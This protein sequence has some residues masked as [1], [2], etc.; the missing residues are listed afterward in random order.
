MTRVGAS[1]STDFRCYDERDA[2]AP[3]G[4]TVITGA[5]AQGKTSLLEAVG[6]VATRPVVPGRRPTRRSCAPGSD[7]A[8]L[9]AEVVDG[10]RAQLLEA[11]IRAQSAATACCC[12]KQRGHAARATCSACC[13][14]RCSRPTTSQ[15]VKGGPAR[16]ARLPRRAARR[17]SRRATTRRAADYERVLQAAQRAAARRRARRRRRARTLDVFD[18][19]LVAGR[20]RARAGPAA[21]ASTG[22]RPAVADAYE[23][24][25]GGRRR[26]RRGATRPSGRRAARR[27]RRRRRSTTLLRAALGG[28]A[29]A[30]ID[31]GRHAGR[32][33]PRRVAA[34]D[35]RARR[36]HARVAGRAAHARARA[37]ARRPPRRARADRH[38]AGAAPRRRVQRARPAP[39]R[40][41]WS[42][43]S[44]RARRWSRPRA[45][46]PPASRAE[47]VLAR[48]RPVASRTPRDATAADAA[49]TSRCRC[50]DALARG[51]RRARHARRPTRSPRSRRV[52]RGRRRRR[53]RRTRPCASVRDGVLTIAVDGPAWAT[54]LRYLETGARGARAAALRA[55]RRDRDRGCASGRATREAGAKS[56]RN[57]TESGTG[58]GTLRAPGT[59]PLTSGFRVLRPACGQPLPHRLPP[60]ARPHST[61]GTRAWRTRP[62]TSRF[63]RASSPSANAPG[64]TS[65]PPVRRASTTSSTRSSTTPSTR[66]WPATRPASTSRCW[67]TAAAASTDNG[68]G[69]PVDNAP[70]VQGQ[71][72]GR[73]RADDAARRRE[74]RR[75]GLQDLR[76]PAR[77]RRVGRQRAVEPA[78]ARDPPRRRQVGCS[79]SRRAASPQGKLERSRRR[80]SST[81]PRS[82]SGPTRRSSRRPSSAR[83]R[84]SSGCARW[85]SSTRASR[86][87]SATSASTRS[88][89]QNFKYDGRHRRLREAPQRV[90]GAAV[91]AGRR[92][93]RTPATTTRSTIAMQWN[94]G[95]YEGI[96]SFANN[97]ATTEGG[98]HEEGFKKALT[99]VVNRYA[100]GKGLLKEKDDNLL[101]EDIREGLTAIISVKLRNPQFE[102]QTKTKLGNTEMRSLVE[103]ATNEKLA[104]WLEEHPTEARQI[105]A[106]ATAGR[107]GPHRGPPGARPHAAQVAAR[108]GGDAGQ[109]RRLLVEGPE[110]VASC[111]S[112]RATAP[113]A[114]PSS[115]RDP[116]IQAIL[117]IR[118]QD[119]QRRARP[120]RQDAEERGDPG[121]H[122]RD[123]RRHRRG[124]RPRQAPLP[125]DHHHDRRRRRRLAHPHAAAHVLLPAAARAREARATSTSR[126]RRCS[127]PTSARSARTSRTKPRCASSR[128]S[129]RAARS[130]SAGSRVSARWTGRSSARPRWTRRRA[131]CCRC[132]SRTPRSPTTSSRTLMGDDVE[133]GAASSRQ[134]AKD[135]RFLDI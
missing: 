122:H 39:R 42:R 60:T 84:C 102:G 75:R 8:I 95:Y 133:S 67:P 120:P 24:L 45:R 96:H 13:G 20:R 80:R 21:A 28:A 114:A 59:G 64:C 115:A 99:N 58:S 91:Q 3:P 88:L 90:E 1:G 7:A 97:I 18:D 10:E 37:A 123:R 38:R 129:T 111:S 35:R 73:G 72:G 36:P 124:V 108:V 94:T 126:S 103:K 121:A 70:R 135:V 104:D 51:R 82:R 46:C 50:G 2:R 78:R 109:A 127:A 65:D 14:S 26:G 69:I 32:A 53:S 63:S 112:S 76:R 56:A 62:R 23:A 93:S 22:W 55:R 29:R 110:R 6:W 68:R 119:P 31:R 41:R 40:A 87:A 74:V 101:G 107:A 33:A 81:A 79:T 92:R 61:R 83:R 44:R 85:R 30:E 9:R 134:N 57:G 89:E 54:Q 130:R 5:N 48:R 49:A 34:R 98:M 113:A 77:R 25:A 4:V 71:V 16:P 66:P 12:N 106:K 11:E 47:R 19:Q 117:P 105:V 132:R 27:R 86:S 116:R 15:L 17:C 100:K 118:G 128:P 52:G 43:T 125:Q 131:R